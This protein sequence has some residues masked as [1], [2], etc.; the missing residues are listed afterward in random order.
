MFIFLFIMTMLVPLT[1]LLLGL[2][3]KTHVPKD[4]NSFYGYRTTMSM[5][6]KDTWEFAH[7]YT[8]K[9]WVWCGTV[10]AILS[11]IPL[12]IFKNS[13][14]FEQIDIIIITVQTF[15]ICL[16]IIPTEIALKKHFDKNGLP[17]EKTKLN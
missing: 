9:V 6:N 10:S 8:A 5:K 14:N 17:K 1:L 3:W 11:A 2:H 16:T 12:L 4:I 13:K 15:L 7:K